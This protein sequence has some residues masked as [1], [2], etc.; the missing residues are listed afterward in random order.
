MDNFFNQGGRAP[1]YSIYLLTVTTVLVATL[2]L[3]APV[4]AQD[5]IRIGVSL[6][7]DGRF[8]SPS[9]MQKSAY[10]LWEKHINEAGGLLG[11]PVEMHFLDDNGEKEKAVENYSLLTEKGGADIVI[12]PYSSGLTIAVAPIV[13]KNGFAML[14]AGASSD[15]V[16]SQGF[17]GIYGMWT[18]ASKYSVG[19]LKV[20]L[21]Q[22]W[23]KVAIVGADDAFSKS[24]AGGAE[25]WSDRLP[26]FEIVYKETFK[27]GT[28]DLT[29]TAQMI[30]NSEAE[31]VLMGGHLNESLDLAA[32]FKE[33][34]WRPKGY[35][36]SVGPTFQ[37]FSDQL[38]DAADCV[39]S[40]SIWE[41]TVD[42][43]GSTE[44]NSAFVEATG[45][46]P[47][48]HAATAYAVGQIVAQAVTQAGSTDQ[49]DLRL[50]LAELDT[51]SII[52][53][54][55]VDRTGLQ[56][57]R[58]PLLIQWQDGTKE[59]ISPEDRQTSVPKVDCGG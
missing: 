8:K 2:L 53:R 7:I 41:P 52:G 12:G 25:T 58:F 20:A 51:Y 40:T 31:L 28:R 32:A 36:A 45:K 30:K 18:P 29:A 33:I 38:G 47:T 24:I 19:M 43:P 6:G 16:W 35:W 39:F 26:G 17:D 9:R 46:T 15:S 42:Y 49:D 56:A 59:I 44:F 57:K 23:H 34:N 11:Q 1:Y 27:K 10:E 3:A 21:R 22:G 37:G 5:A 54:Y 13:D 14:A 48:Y 4:N 55:A 50:V